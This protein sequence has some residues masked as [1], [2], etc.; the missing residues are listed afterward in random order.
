LH[1]LADALLSTHALGDIGHHFPP[2]NPVFE[3]L[4]SSIIVQE[5]LER[6]EERA[7]EVIVHN[8]AAVVTLDHPK[9]GGY[10]DAMQA[11]IAKLLELETSNVGV[12]FKTSE[13][14]AP[15]HIQA[16]VTVLVSSRVGVT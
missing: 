10:R 15:G 6:L 11:Q 16:R 3:G 13:G 5:V 7:G 14:L 4:D 2:S 8:V 9:L 1:A 12:T